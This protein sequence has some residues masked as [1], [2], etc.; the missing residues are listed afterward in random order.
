MAL[1]F[2]MESPECFEPQMC[3]AEHTVPEPMADL[4]A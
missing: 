1:H 3:A 4:T 2:Y